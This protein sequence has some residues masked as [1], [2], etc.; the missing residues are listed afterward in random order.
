LERI[1]HKAVTLDAIELFKM[2]GGNH[3]PVMAV[4]AQI[5]GAGMAGV[6]GTFIDHLQEAG[7]KASLQSGHHEGLPRSI[8]G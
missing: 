1:I 7:L 3:H 5:I 2:A 6:L 8:G 4:Q